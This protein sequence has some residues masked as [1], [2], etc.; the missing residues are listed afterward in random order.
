MTFVHSARRRLL[1]DTLFVADLIVLA[2]ALVAAEWIAT[3]GS[4]SRLRRGGNVGLSLEI[5]EVAFLVLFAVAWHAILASVG[6]YRSRRMALLFSEWWDITKSVGLAT[7]LLAAVA[8]FSQSSSLERSFLASFAGVSLGGM[9]VIRTVMRW[10]LGEVR[11]RGR[12]LRNIVIIGA[13][14]RGATFAEMIRKKPELGYLLLGFIDDLPPPRSALHGQ[15][16]KQLGT[17]SDVEKLLRTLPVDEVALTLPFKSYWGTMAEIVA[18][19]EEQ[20]IIVR[21]PANFFEVHLSTA[22]IDQVEQLAMMTLHTPVPG[23]AGHLIKRLIDAAGAA[24]ILM[25]LLPVFVVIAILTKLDSSGPVFFV[26]ERI[27]LG[28]RPFP[29]IKFRTMVVDAEKRLAELE[30]KNEVEGAAFKMQRDPRVTR[31]GR[32]LRKLSLDELPQ[33]W[34]VLRGDMSLVGPRPL[35]MRD[36]ER[37]ETPWQNRRFSVKPGLTCLWQVSGRHEIRF[38]HWMELDL[39]YIDNWSLKLDFEIMFRTLPAV[40]R[41]TGAS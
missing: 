15:A 3:D 17:L 7:L 30:E 41:G 23:P 24:L 9:I 6:L 28:K 22:S 14:P 39:Q 37:F 19:C 20:G 12:N 13:G 31:V 38:D 16:E 27:G 5:A 18:L 25:L 2:A 29:M 33:L 11:R 4:S 32:V 10:F 1:L 8:V 34:N 26:Q 36:V 35:P 21:I 40:M